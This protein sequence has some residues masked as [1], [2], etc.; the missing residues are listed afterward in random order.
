MSVNKLILREKLEFLMLRNP[1]KKAEFRKKLELKV[2]KGR[3]GGG[4][5]KFPN[6]GKN[7]DAALTRLTSPRLFPRDNFP[8]PPPP[9]LCDPPPL[10][11]HP[12]PQ[13][14]PS[15]VDQADPSNQ[16]GKIIIITPPLLLP[17]EW[18][19]QSGDKNDFFI[20]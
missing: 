18:T 5:G 6:G 16:S 20:D 13:S 15:R 9:S 7:R 19:R 14:G 4:R 12:S 2:C 1:S 3:R 8:R 11:H 10:P 17:P